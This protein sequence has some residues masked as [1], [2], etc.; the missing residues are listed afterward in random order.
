MT[1]PTTRSLS[2]ESTHASSSCSNALTNAVMRIPLSSAD[3]DVDIAA[4]I[5]LLL[6]QKENERDV[7]GRRVGGLSLG[8]GHHAGHQRGAAVD[9]DL[10]ED[11]LQVPLHRALGAAEL[12]GDRAIVP[13]ARDG[14]G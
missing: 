5:R 13:A 12:P 2:M 14:G 11:I 10:V 8:S 9:A 1:G 6:F 4:R 7:T 3:A